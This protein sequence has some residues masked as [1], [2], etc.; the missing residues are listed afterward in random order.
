LNLITRF[1][2]HEAAGMAFDHDDGKIKE[3][4]LCIPEIGDMVV[5]NTKDGIT[6]KSFELNKKF[7]EYLKLA[8]NTG[9]SKLCLGVEE[10]VVDQIKHRYNSLI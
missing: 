4:I 1:I 9:S 6:V 2:A 5:E 3:C 7:C 8:L 10:R